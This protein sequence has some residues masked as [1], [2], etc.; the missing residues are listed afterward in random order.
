MVELRKFSL[1]RKVVPILI[2]D[3]N[4]NEFECRLEEMTGTERDSWLSGMSRR[5]KTDANGNPT[6]VSSFDGLQADLIGLCLTQNG[7]KVPK[8]EIMKYPASLQTELFKIC[9]EINSL[10]DKARDEAKNG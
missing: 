8:S 6:G 3:E 4:G 10:G 5:M 1:K 7:V 9:Q 2:E